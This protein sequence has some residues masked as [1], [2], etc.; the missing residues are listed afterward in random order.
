MQKISASQKHGK[1]CNQ[2][3]SNLR[4]AAAQNTFR[5]IRPKYTKIK[6][7]LSFAEEQPSKV[8]GRQFYKHVPQQL[9]RN[10]VS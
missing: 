2:T 4:T 8:V 6:P 5:S 10:E 3:P 7:P 1:Y 9:D